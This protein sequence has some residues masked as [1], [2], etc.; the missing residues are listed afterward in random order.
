MVFSPCQRLPSMVGRRSDCCFIT[1]TA[2]SPSRH[3]GP[4]DSMC[5]NGE[6]DMQYGLRSFMA[7]R[8][9]ILRAA[10]AFSMSKGHLLRQRNELDR[11]R[12]LH[13]SRHCHPQLRSKYPPW[14]GLVDWVWR[15]PVRLRQKV[16]GSNNTPSTWIKSHPLLRGHTPVFAGTY[17]RY[18]GDVITC[19]CRSRSTV[20]R[21]SSS[22]SSSST[23]AVQSSISS[24]SSSTAAV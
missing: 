17:T 13:R 11:R 7:T 23:R 16:D 12:Q 18:C 19:L 5:R 3:G 6:S 15:N 9:A 2:G 24:S 14:C 20:E 8:F 1:A 10:A 4:R 22:S 21:S